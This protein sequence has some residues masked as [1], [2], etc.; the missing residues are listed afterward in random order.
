MRILAWNC[1]GAGADLTTRQLEEMCRLY[2]PGFVFL[3]ETKKDRMH[4]QNMQVSLGFDSLQT[5]EPIGNSGGLALFYSKDYPVKFV[6]LNDRL[7]D[8]ETII[9]GNRVLLL[10]MAIR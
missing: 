8:I 1:E 2:S 4:L 10:F 3:S 5:V 6:F 9:D 7:I